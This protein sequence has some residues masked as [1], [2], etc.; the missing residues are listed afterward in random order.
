MGNLI[1]FPSIESQ[2]P[3]WEIAETNTPPHPEKEI[4][5][6]NNPRPHPEKEIAKTNI[7]IPPQKEKNLQET[8]EEVKEVVVDDVVSESKTRENKMQV[9][10][11]DD[12]KMS[13]EEPEGKMADFPP[14]V[15]DHEEVHKEE[16]ERGTRIGN[17]LNAKEEEGQQQEDKEHDNDDDEF[18]KMSNEELNRRV[19]EFIQRFNRQIR[20]QAAQNRVQQMQRGN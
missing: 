13:I 2:Y 4:P 7:P 6:T 1:R 11:K 5:K 17:E 20:I 16:K 12:L 14:Q 19:E 10:V 18:S 3:E 9:V 15:L 8:Q